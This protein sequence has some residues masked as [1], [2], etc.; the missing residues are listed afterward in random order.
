[1]WYCSQC[2]K[3]F[4]ALSL[5][6]A[7][8]PCSTIKSCVNHVLASY[9]MKD[10]YTFVLNTLLFLKSDILIHQHLQ[11]FTMK[12]QID[13][14]KSHW[15]TFSIDSAIELIQLNEHF[16]L[17]EEI[18][19]VGTSAINALTVFLSASCA[20]HQSGSQN[21]DWLLEFIASTLINYHHYH[22]ENEKKTFFS[23]WYIING[24]T[25]LF[26]NKIYSVSNW[27]QTEDLMDKSFGYG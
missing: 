7:P 14:I 17:L 5:Q 26:M 13:A 21:Y 3:S 15:N 4:A 2:T 22:S 8:Y 24:S 1:M 10:L 19:A 12:I 11:D 23:L 9:I 25:T 20:F 6:F 16:L 18:T 27:T